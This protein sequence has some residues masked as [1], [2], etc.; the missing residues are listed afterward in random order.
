MKTKIGK[1]SWLE[2]RKKQSNHKGHEGR[3]KGS[4]TRRDHVSHP[5][6]NQSSNKF[7]PFAGPESSALRLLP[8]FQELGQAFVGEG[9]VEHHVEHFERKSGDVGAG[10]RGFHHVKWMPQ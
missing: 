2:K 1:S 8:V 7:P 10:E 9:M 4:R 6:G 3:T 5:F